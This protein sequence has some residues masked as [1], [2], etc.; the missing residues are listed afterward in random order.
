[1][2]CFVQPQRMNEIIHSFIHQEIRWNQRLPLLSKI[3][4]TQKDP[5]GFLSYMQ[6]ESSR[7]TPGRGTVGVGTREVGGGGGAF[8]KR[9]TC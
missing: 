4:Q 9:R 2:E 6:P 1:M 5:A 7:E 8:I 3:S